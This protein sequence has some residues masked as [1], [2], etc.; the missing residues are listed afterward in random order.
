MDVMTL[1]V[2][3]ELSLR[4]SLGLPSN[5]VSHVTRDVMISKTPVAG[6]M[7]TAYRIGYIYTY[8]LK[9]EFKQI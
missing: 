1:Q 3:D 8:F 7:S 6:E 4:G 5:C 9:P 2:G